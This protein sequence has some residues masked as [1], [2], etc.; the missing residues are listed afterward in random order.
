VAET[1]N[2]IWKSRIVKLI[3]KTLFQINKI[4]KMK[5]KSSTVK[6]FICKTLFLVSCFLLGFAATIKCDAQS[7]V[8]KWH[9][10]GTKI[11]VT[12][13]ANGTHKPLSAQQ[14]KQFDD[15]AIANGYNELLEFK[16]NNTYVSKVSAKGK[17]PTEHTEKYSLSGNKLDM[18]IPPVNNEKT[19]ITIKSIDATTMV[20]DL[21][22]MGELTEV[23][24]T[25]I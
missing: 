10:G 3:F 9:R 13:K 14:Q 17:E 7:I 21:M 11:F 1:N 5:T 12:D 15:A 8:G 16:S 20:W 4:R 23:I 19:T 22:F 24:Y 25:R 18:N 2:R 6:A